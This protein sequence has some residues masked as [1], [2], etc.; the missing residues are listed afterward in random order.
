MTRSFLVG[1]S[2]PLQARLSLFAQH[3][4]EARGPKRP[5]GVDTQPDID[6]VPEAESNR[7]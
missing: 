2:R 6:E 1:A 7:A 4:P 3:P 5:G